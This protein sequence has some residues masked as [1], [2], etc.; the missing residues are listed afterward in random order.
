MSRW[1]AAIAGLLLG[2][3]L[4][5]GC[6]DGDEPPRVEEASLH[7]PTPL[8][9]CPDEDYR[10][11]DVRDPECLKALSQ[12]TA[13]LRQSRP[14]QI[15]TELLTEDAYRDQLLRRSAEDEPSMPHFDRALSSLGLAPP[16]SPPVSALIEERVTNLGGFYDSIEKRIVIID[17]GRPADGPETDAVLVHEL[18][19]SLQ[20]ADYDLAHWPEDEPQSFDA[21]LAARTL[22][23]GE[24]SLYEYRAAAALFGLDVGEVDLE[25]ALQH[26]LSS[27]LEDALQATS[28][29]P[30]SFRT[31]PYGMGALRAFAAWQQGG[32]R[33]V[34]A[35]WAVPPRT[36]Q[37]VMAELFGMN[38]PQDSGIEITA[39]VID[40]LT[41]DSHE[42][43][44]AWCLYFLQMQ[45]GS[46]APLESALSWRGD[47]FWVYTDESSATYAL[48]QL[49]F[50]GG[51][52]ARAWNEFFNSRN[53][54]PTRFGT[55][56]ATFLSE[57]A[58]SRVYVSYA[59]GGRPPAAPLT[60]WGK[61]WLAER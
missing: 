55:A 25:S 59:Y 57:T 3:W 7:P 6:G 19:H 23:E 20:D 37:R 30:T 14:L 31:L 61:A 10:S 8:P 13:C 27:A 45:A 58:G 53:G 34:D 17:H 4:I 42:V 9:E 1:A 5:T 36:M 35:L 47:H 41:L 32:P 11:C 56:A 26:H 49:E 38:E 48:W 52:A 22:V 15:P 50:D 18:V 39:P 46:T 54:R 43:L 16:K 44:G 60:T 21:A 40:Q 24:A 51:T 12:L 28:V 33:G 2:P 29:L